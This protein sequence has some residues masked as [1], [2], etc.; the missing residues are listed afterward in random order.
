MK[1][2]SFIAGMGSAVVLSAPAIARASQA[3]GP[4]VVVVGGGYGGAT[5]AKYL[6]QFSKGKIHVTLVEPQK[7]FISC[8]ISNLVLEGALSI[9]DITMGYQGLSDRHGV[10]VVHDTVTRIDQDARKVHLAGGDVLEWDRLILS[11]GID[12]MWNRLPGMNKAGA[13]EKIFHA[14]KAGPQTVALRKQLEAMP[15]GGRFIIAVPEAPY[16]C[17]PG[18][19]ERACMV[20]SYFKKHKPKS[21]VQI[22]DAN[23]DVTSKG[24]LFKAAWKTHYPNI[25]EHIPMFKAVDVDA[26]ENTVIF[27]LGEREKADVLNL[28]PPMRAGKVAVDAGLATANDRWCEVDFLTFASVKNDHIHVLGDAIQVAPQMPKSGHMANQHGK[29]C[30]AAV[31]ALLMGQPVNSLPIYANTCFSFVT[32]AEA[33]HVASA[34]RYNAEKKTMLP[35]EGS[36]GVSRESSVQEGNHART[37]ARSIWNDTLG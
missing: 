28:I 10:K 11:P 27:E 5:A 7:N 36:G 17:P 9:D 25:V 24:G 29:N 16:R 23:Q 14:W 15:D 8:P 34:H 37:W 35:V 3:S 18:P 19:Y 31:T 12:F 6:R 30:A 20:A 33:M 1:R 32:D 22:F 21:K 13:Q 2:R 26:A 4:R